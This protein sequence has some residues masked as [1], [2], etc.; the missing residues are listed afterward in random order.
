[1]AVSG[2]Y[3]LRLGL[4]FITIRAQLA[5]IFLVRT[6]QARAAE[7]RVALTLGRN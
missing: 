3:D 6:H 7:T 4:R 5:L 2:A 1:M